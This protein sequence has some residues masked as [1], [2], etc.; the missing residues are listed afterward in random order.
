MGAGNEI[1]EFVRRSP[2]LQLFLVGFLAL[3]LQI[4]VVMIDSVTGERA[5]RRA[6]AIEEVTASWGREQLLTGPV[7]AVPYV[8]RWSEEVDGKARSRS[9]LRH[10]VFLPDELSIRGRIDGEIRRRGIFDIP[11]YRAA[12]EVAGSFT[13]PDLGAWAQAEDVR[14]ERAELSVG[15]SDVR[16]IQTR[17]A[18]RWNGESLEFQPGSGE[19]GGGR[20]GIFTPI[21][22]RLAGDRSS[23]SFPLPLNGSVSLALTPLGRD[24]AA[25][26]ESNWRD[27]SFQGSWLPTERSVGAEGFSATWRIPF[28]GRGYPQAWTSEAEPADAV[29]AS[30]F[31]VSLLPPVDPYRM[32][33]R[34]TKY[35]L[36]FF[37]L[38][39]AALWLFEVLSDARVHSVQYLMTGGAMCLF[40]LLMLSLSEHV[41]FALGYAIAS[42]GVVALL[43]GYGVV[44][45]RLSGRAGVL[46]GLVAA[47]YAYLYLLL[48]EADY[49]LLI[50]SIGLFAIL[51]GAMFLTRKVD[52][53][54]PKRAS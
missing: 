2:L 20:A 45:L 22:K 39:F 5:E 48:R 17:V 26:L 44:M 30:S 7:V 31:G 11:L 18:I 25:E 37:A 54:A 12:L 9:E 15:I 35:S 43:F 33:E 53:Y 32:A 4:P 6:A 49:A 23:F 21:G 34:S 19:F 14:W 38:V 41:G 24:T 10:A 27:P 36:L 47:L 16:A 29:R 40:Y 46:A 8:H 3:V 51:A 28:L 50:G 1:A 52:W 13:R 42:G